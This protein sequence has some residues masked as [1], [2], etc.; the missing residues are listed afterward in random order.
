M[1]GA[2]CRRPCWSLHSSARK[3]LAPWPSR[4]LCITCAQPDSTTAGQEAGCSAVL[5]NPLCHVVSEQGHS[6]QCSQQFRGCAQHR[7][8]KLSR[9]VSCTASS[10][11]ATAAASMLMSPGAPG[12]SVPLL[13]APSAGA[14]AGT[15][16]AD[17]RPTGTLCPCMG[18]N[19]LSHL[20]APCGDVHAACTATPLEHTSGLCK[21]RLQASTMCE[22]PLPGPTACGGAGAAAGCCTAAG[23]GGGPA[24]AATARIMRW[25]HSYLVLTFSARS[26]RLVWSLTMGLQVRHAHTR[27]L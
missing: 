18:V 21:D 5:R 27:P 13:E 16:S 8:S 17:Q 24:A 12:G 1:G 11:A 15:Q 23:G 20:A 6:V 19:S 3:N 25:I 10:S 7:T 22:A 26:T 9:L 2:G 4:V 14:G